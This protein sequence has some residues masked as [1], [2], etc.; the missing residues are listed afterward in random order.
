MLKKTVHGEIEARKGPD[1]KVT[2]EELL[3]I[4]REILC[5]GDR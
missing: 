1:G 2:Y 4:W 5:G 3:E